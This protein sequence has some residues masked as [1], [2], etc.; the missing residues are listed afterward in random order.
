MFAVINNSLSRMRRNAD[1]TFGPQ[2]LRIGILGFG[3]LGQFLCTH[4][5]RERTKPT[6]DFVKIVFERF[7][8]NIRSKSRVGFVRSRSKCVQR[9]CPR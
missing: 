1:S 4:F 2:P 6:R 8:I 7:H 3:H 5:E 9:N